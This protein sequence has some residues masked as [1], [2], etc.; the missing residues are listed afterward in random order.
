MFSNIHNIII[1]LLM[2]I[3]Y[4]PDNCILH[5]LGYMFFL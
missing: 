4:V 5:V 1:Y 2:Y 3:V